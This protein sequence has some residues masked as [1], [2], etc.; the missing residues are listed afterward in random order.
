M[1]IKEKQFKS[2]LILGYAVLTCSLFLC[3][4]T[5]C[6]PLVCH[7]LFQAILRPWHALPI[8]V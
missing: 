2:A 8:T 1:E 6:F 5:A 7:L 3:S 4:V